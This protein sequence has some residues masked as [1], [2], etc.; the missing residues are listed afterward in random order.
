ME[1]Y[2]VGT[3]KKWL[4]ETLQMGT[5]NIYFHGEIREICPD[6][7]YQEQRIMQSCIIEK[8]G[9]TVYYF[10][11]TNICCEYSLEA[12]RQG[13]A[14]D[15]H[16]IFEKLK[17]STSYL[18]ILLPNRYSENIDIFLFSPLWKLHRHVN[19]SHLYLKV[20]YPSNPPPSLIRVYFSHH[21]VCHFKTHI[22][23]P[24]N[25]EYFFP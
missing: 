17:N 5:H 4:N 11:H 3:H 23:C 2:V 16:K 21:L 25:F 9:I 1:T 24:I 7:S 10:L 13:T 12:T 19:W 8:S 22:V 6:T 20:K 14:H 18:H 15:T